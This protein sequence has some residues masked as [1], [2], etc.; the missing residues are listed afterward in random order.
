MCLVA[1][2]PVSTWMGD[3]LG[4]QGAVGILHF[5]FSFVNLNE[6]PMTFFAFLMHIL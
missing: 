4:T 6:R 5:L 1:L 2:S 3:R